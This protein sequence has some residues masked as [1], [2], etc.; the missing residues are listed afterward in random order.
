MKCLTDK[1]SEADMETHVLKPLGE[2][3]IKI[4]DA[5]EA[6]SEDKE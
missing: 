2:R 5:P 1:L 6:A 4:L 3:D